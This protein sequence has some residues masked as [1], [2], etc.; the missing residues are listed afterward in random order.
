[1]NAIDFLI[2]EHNKVR[3]M[4]V[5][6]E[7]TSHKFDTQKKRFELL[8]QDLIRHENMEHE[9]WYPHFK[10]SLPDTVK[11][12]VKEERNAEKEIKKIEQLK[13]ESSWKEHFIKFKQAVEHHATEEEQKLFPEVKKILS[14]D[15]LRQI[16]AEMLVYKKEHSE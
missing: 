8:S 9:V 5:D 2:N 3:N 7:D 16:G 6:I 11:H 10:N 4:M 1:M 15:V 14:E 12:L 13:T